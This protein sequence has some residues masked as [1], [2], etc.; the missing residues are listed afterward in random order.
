[1]KEP[2]V[3]D[4]AGF[5]VLARLAAGQALVALARRQI[6][7]IGAGATHRTIVL[8]VDTSWYLVAAVVALAVAR[9]VASGSARLARGRG[10]ALR[11]VR[12]GLAAGLALA[13]TSQ[14][15]SGGAGETLLG[16]PAA[17]NAL[18]DGFVAHAAD[19]LGCRSVTVV[20]AQAFVLGLRTVGAVGNRGRTES[21]S[22]GGGGR[23]S[24]RA[25]E[26]LALR[27]R[28]RTA[29]RNFRTTLRAGRI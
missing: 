2:V 14:T 29:V 25:R 27:L 17:R 9:Q 13:I 11:A 4:I 23:V 15:V 19:T 28:T 6:V 18:R 5:A 21:A 1:M 3:A 22:G 16:C 7:F 10:R 20:A 12:D 26:A 8:A 24:R